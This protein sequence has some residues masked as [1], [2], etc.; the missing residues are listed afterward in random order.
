MSKSKKMSEASALPVTQTDISHGTEMW[1]RAQG[2]CDFVVP[3]FRINLGTPKELLVIGT[4]EA[5]IYITKEQCM[6]AYNL[7]PNLN[8]SE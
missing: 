8:S 5:A 2:A 4:K 3:A 7:V 6:A 1:L